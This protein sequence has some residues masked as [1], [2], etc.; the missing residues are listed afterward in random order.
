M[1]LYNNDLI[2]SNVGNIFSG[3]PWFKPVCLL[4][5]WVC[6]IT[7]AS[8]KLS[9]MEIA[10]KEDKLFRETIYNAEIPYRVNYHG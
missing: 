6:P 5:F 4:K 9:D 8:N 2:V 7:H 3:H 1:I 10:I